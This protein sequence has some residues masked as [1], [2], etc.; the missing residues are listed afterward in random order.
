MG[1]FSIINDHSA[2]CFPFEEMAS[3]CQAFSQL[4]AAL[5]M[6][7]RFLACCFFTALQLTERAFKKQ[8]NK[9]NKQSQFA[10]RVSF[11]MFKSSYKE[12]NQLW[13]KG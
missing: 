7:D 2:K 11:V 4:G 8:R 6:A 13:G 5:K 3:G 10:P 12:Q 9:K 1:V